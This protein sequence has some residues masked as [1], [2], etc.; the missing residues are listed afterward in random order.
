MSKITSKSMKIIGSHIKEV[1]DEIKEQPIKEAVEKITNAEKIFVVGA[2]RSGLAAKMF[3][4][5]LMH[6]GLNV[7]VV[8]ETINPS[9]NQKDLVIAISGSG[10]TS[11]TVEVSKTTKEVGAKLISITSSPNSEIS[12]LSDVSI[13]IRDQLEKKEISQEEIA[14]LGTL[15]ELT[16][17][18][19][20][21]SIISE[22][23]NVMN[24]N[25]K[26]LSKKH[27][28]LE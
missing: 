21:D 10:E 18:V 7:Y 28:T 15:F 1:G 23:M 2:G 4:M 24:K 22:L 14:P 17:A 25:E 9:L 26:D 5:R 3:A 6:L 8:G 13:T 12:S 19:L 16:A 20:M 11:S 27:A